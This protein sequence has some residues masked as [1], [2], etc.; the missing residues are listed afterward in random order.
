VWPDEFTYGKKR[1]ILLFALSMIF[2][3]Q[4]NV[5]SSVDDVRLNM[6]H[7]ILELMTVR[8]GAFLFSNDVLLLSNVS[9]VI[10]WCSVSS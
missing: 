8:L 7:F 6:A 9:A 4:S 5:F 2:I 3:S 10:E 1:C